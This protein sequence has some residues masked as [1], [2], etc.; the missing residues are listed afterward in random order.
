MR[1]HESIA[2]N[3]V[4]LAVARIRELQQRYSEVTTER[5]EQRVARALMRLASLDLTSSAE[6]TVDFPISR[7]DIA[8]AAGTT[9]YTASRLLSSWESDGLIRST[10]RHVVI[11]RPAALAKIADTR[12]L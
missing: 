12:S 4:H 8:D 6:I 5:V 3:A 2:L 1:T 10:R 11:V 9:L 7:Q